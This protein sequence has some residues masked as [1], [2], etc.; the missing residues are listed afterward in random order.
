MILLSIVHDPEGHLLSAAK[1]HLPD[2][3]NLF[4]GAIFNTTS[5]TDGR[6]QELLS[7]LATYNR[8]EPASGI[9]NARRQALRDSLDKTNGNHFFYCDLDRLLH[10]QMTYPDEL[11]KTIPKV[12]MFDFT[13]LCRTRLA[14]RSH[15]FL[16]RVTE[17]ACNFVF[18]TFKMG[19]YY[20][21]ILAAT[22]GISREVGHAIVSTSRANGC[23]VDAEWPAIARAGN[24]YVADVY[25]NGLGYES[26]GFDIRKGWVAEIKMRFDNV[27]TIA[28]ASLLM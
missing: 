28:Q 16:Q 12:E 3:V 4:D 22:R 14:W 7:S 17:W 5:Q 9:S 11:M 13:V 21:D 19:G 2:V 8:V 6:L 23:A 10:W 24:W 26:T 25:V 20:V 15:P 27:F 1:Q 18:S